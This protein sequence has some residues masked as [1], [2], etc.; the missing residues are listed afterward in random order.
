MLDIIEFELRIIPLTFQW[1]L[2]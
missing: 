1:G 2:D